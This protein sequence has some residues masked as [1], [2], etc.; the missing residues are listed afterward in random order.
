MSNDA[1]PSQVL[2]GD[3]VHDDTDALQ[4]LK[5]NLRVAVHME[6][7]RWDGMPKD[8]SPSRR[9]PVQPLSAV[10]QPDALL[11]RETVQALIGLRKTAVNEMVARGEF[12]RPLYLNPREPRWVAADV[13]AW[14]K[15]ISTRDGSG[16][17]SVD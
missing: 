7:Q 9:A 8:H 3:G 4:A 13:L 2:Y 1:E 17:C 14:L 12:P 5:G 10:Y 6:H 16:R 11:L 15:S